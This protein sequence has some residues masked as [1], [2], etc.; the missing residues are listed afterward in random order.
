M[1][2][3]KAVEAVTEAAKAGFFT[4]KRLVAIAATVAVAAGVT[5]YLKSRKNQAEEVEVQEAQP[6]VAVKR[7]AHEKK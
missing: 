4:P 7:A 2:E 3:N 6:A 1:Q 5:L